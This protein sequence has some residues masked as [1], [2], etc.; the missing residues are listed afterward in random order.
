MVNNKK[1]DSFWDVWMHK[2]SNNTWSI[3]SL[4][5]EA[6]TFVLLGNTII[7]RRPFKDNNEY[8]EFNTFLLNNEI[9]TKQLNYNGNISK[10]E[11]NSITI[12]DNFTRSKVVTLL[13]SIP[14]GISKDTLKLIVMT[15][16]EVNNII[17][18][19]QLEPEAFNWIRRHIV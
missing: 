6:W 17:N 1:Q 7:F 16:E 3:H 9:D 2:T 15:Q 11:C 13:E 8:N 19:R 12:N 5:I 4:D 14:L 10:W 18:N